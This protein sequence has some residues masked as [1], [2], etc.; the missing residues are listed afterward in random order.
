MGGTESYLAALVPALGDAGH[1]VAFFHAVDVPADRGAMELPA[2]VPAWCVAERGANRALAELRDWRPDVLYVH[3]L[4]DPVLEERLLDVAP[5]VLFLHNY[6]G[7]CVSGAKTFKN[8]V[9]RPCSRTFGPA[10]LLHYYPHRC[11][12]WNPLTMVRLYRQQA[13]R[14]R[15]LSRYRLLL[16]HSEHMRQEYLR[17]G[18]PSERVRVI[19]YFVPGPMPDELAPAEERPPDA[20]FRLLFLGRMDLL[21]GG[22]VLLD[23]LPEAAARLRRPLHLT[24]AGDGPLR[25]RWQEQARALTA[26]H[27]AIAV[28]FPGWLNE[29]QKA[30]Q[31]RQTDLLVMPSLWPEPFGMVGVEA[32]RFGV[33][34][35]AF[36]VGGVRAWLQDGVNGVLAGGAVPTAT[37]L[38]KAIA[39]CLS[40]SGETFRNTARRSASGFT[41][42][43]HVSALNACLDHA[44]GPLHPKS[45]RK[46]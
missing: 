28:A 21:K 35:V 17:H 37:H 33:P 16:T 45:V 18:L 43:P 4:S 34:A 20:P 42:T 2:S 30:A 29:E 9:V 14:L 31:F 11:G 44:V 22:H 19:P 7:T 32:G 26:G 3:G 24:M 10:C 39:S 1:A 5:A 41:R 8:P 40:G 15:L 46:Q 27:P 12:G 25:S 36:D 13:H 38:A 23:A 6:Y